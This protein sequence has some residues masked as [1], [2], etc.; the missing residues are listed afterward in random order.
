MALTIRLALR[1]WDWVTPLALGDV[2]PDGFAL[3]I[4]RVGT[5]PEDLA[6]DPL[7]DAGEMSLSRYALGR[8]R[9]EAGIVGVPHFLMRGFRH[10]CVITARDSGLT[11]LAQLAGKRIGLTGWPDSGN[12][13]TRALLRR[14]GIGVDD[15][16]WFLGRLTEAHPVT[17]RLGGFG[18]PGQ[19]EAAPGERPMLELLL[20]GGLD[21]VFTPFMPP[22]FFEAESPFRALLPDYRGTEIAYGRAVGYVPGIHVLGIKPAV[23]RDHPWLPQALG[24]VLDESARVWAGKRVKYADTTPWIL[25]ELR[26]CALDLPPGWDRN[27]FAANERMIDDFLAEQQAQGL[28]PVRQS[29]RDLFPGF[30]VS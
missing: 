22:G 11:T 14:E 8:A 26:R 29:P 16:R 12:T 6:T 4:D 13:W 19:I 24:E 2:R 10:R 1:D 3:A 25:D 15:A 23:V 20:A 27:G 28:T 5:L 18:R 7:Y 17:D 9:G 30:G 21:A